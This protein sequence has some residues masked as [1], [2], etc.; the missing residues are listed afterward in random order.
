MQG[1]ILATLPQDLGKRIR[2][3]H[4]LVMTVEPA[5]C[6]GCGNAKAAHLIQGETDSFGFEPVAL[7]SA[8]YEQTEAQIEH[9]LEARDVEDREPKPGHV[10]FVSEGTNHDGHGD[11]CRAF[12]SFR[13][14]TAFYQRIEEKA[15]PWCGLYPGKGVREIPEAER[16]LAAYRQRILEA[17]ALEAEYDFDDGVDQY[18]DDLFDDLDDLDDLDG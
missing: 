4:D 10:F 8:C 11:W 7:C 15:A 5:C 3:G 13:D 6:E 18:E 16:Y 17:E 12:R 9:R 14:A 2:F 1:D